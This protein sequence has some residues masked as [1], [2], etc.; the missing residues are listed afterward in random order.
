MKKLTD[1]MKRLNDLMA[2]GRRKLP[3]KV[4]QICLEEGFVLTLDGRVARLL[5][6][7]E[8]PPDCTIHTS[9]D[10][11]ET[12]LTTPAQAPLLAMTGKLRISNLQLGIDLG[13]A[14]QELLSCERAAAK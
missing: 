9:F 8:V 13:K 11:L 3:Q 5:E 6:S 7:D 10:H 1:L 2:T 14:L 4:Y 12:L